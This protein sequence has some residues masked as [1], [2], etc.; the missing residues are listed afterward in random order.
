MLLYYH[1]RSYREKHQALSSTKNFKQK[2][3]HHQTAQ[4][5]VERLTWVI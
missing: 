5:Q 4:Q 2:A 1:T 3:I